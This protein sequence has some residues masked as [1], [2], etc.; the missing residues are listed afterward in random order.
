[1]EDSSPKYSMASVTSAWLTVSL[2][3]FSNHGK[4]INTFNLTAIGPKSLRATDNVFSDF[5]HTNLS[6]SLTSRKRFSLQSSG[7]AVRITVLAMH[8]ENI[9]KIQPV[10]KSKYVPCLARDLQRKLKNPKNNMSRRDLCGKVGV[11]KK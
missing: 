11:E 3:I 9:E 5:K 6:S 1:M 7:D 2:S 10:E 8:D 4:R